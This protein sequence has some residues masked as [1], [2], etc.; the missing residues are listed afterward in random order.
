VK[1]KQISLDK[2]MSNF[3]IAKYL[4][5]ELGTEKREIIIMQGGIL[6]LNGG[7]P[8]ERVIGRIVSGNSII[9]SDPEIAKKALGIAKITEDEDE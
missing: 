7:K 3:E 1:E 9:V 4:G 6:I 2:Y 8:D 5:V